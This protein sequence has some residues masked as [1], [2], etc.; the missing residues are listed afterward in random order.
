MFTLSELGLGSEIS[1]A[2]EEAGIG[3]V[4]ELADKTEEQ[5]AAIA[6]SENVA[7]VR[8]KI[9]AI[10]LRLDIN[11]DR[12][13]DMDSNCPASPDGK[14]VWEKITAVSDTVYMEFEC[15]ECGERMFLI[16]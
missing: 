1:R 16:L 2:L 11:R 4:P 6:G 7:E 3:S 5:I 14:H 15:C 13:V 12:F 8:E 10:G 9:K